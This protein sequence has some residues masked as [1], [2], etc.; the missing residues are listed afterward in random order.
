ML[1]T[2]NKSPFEKDSLETCFRLAKDGS[3]ILLLED[4]VYAAIV[5][6]RLEGKM[7]EALERCAVFALEADVRARGIESRDLIPGISIVDYD[8]FV[9]LAINNECVQCWL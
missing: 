8:G 9:D 2:V 7:H 6:T 4:A 5:G 1:H 3:D